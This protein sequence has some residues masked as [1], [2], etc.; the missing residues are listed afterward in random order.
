MTAETIK[1]IENGKRLYSRWKE[2]NPK[3]RFHQYY[4]HRVMVSYEL[5]KPQHA[6]GLNVPNIDAFLSDGES[7]RDFLISKGLTEDSICVD[8]GCGGLRH[9]IPLIN[10]L[11][12]GN[13][14]GLDVTDIF[15]QLAI[16]EHG[17]MIQKAKHTF[18][19]I[20][21]ENLS[22]IRRLKPDYIISFAVMCHIP[23]FELNEYVKNLL[24][25]MSKHT[26]CYVTAVVCD[27]PCMI[28]GKDWAYTEQ[29]LSETFHSFGGKIE[30]DNTIEF[31]RPGVEKTLF[32]M[33]Y[34]VTIDK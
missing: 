5:G 28:A 26:K 6:L 10:F 1:N 3:K 30:V 16:K 25:I 12:D 21:A 14:Y 19:V 27:E 2:E 7:N 33:R 29:A 11:T 31:H 32:D 23:P 15:Y 13:Y 34:S 17:S 9:G 24:S 8:Y 20:S 22:R 18:L 4:A